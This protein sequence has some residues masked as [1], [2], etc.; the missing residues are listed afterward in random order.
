MRHLWTGQTFIAKWGSGI[1]EFDNGTEQVEFRPLLLNIMK[2]GHCLKAIHSGCY[3]RFFQW[4]G[5]FSSVLYF[6]HSSLALISS[7][8]FR[9]CTRSK[10]NCYVDWGFYHKSVS[11]PG[12]ACI[13]MAEPWKKRWVF[14]NNEERLSVFWAQNVSPVVAREEGTGALQKGPE[15]IS[16]PWDFWNDFSEPYYHGICIA[17]GQTFSLLIFSQ[18]LFA[19]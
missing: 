3:L 12:L 17:N 8:A 2:T 19:L 10:H 14:P 9:R 15:A 16:E 6:L 13:A 4:A 5:R 1:Q 18:K 7:S 11:I